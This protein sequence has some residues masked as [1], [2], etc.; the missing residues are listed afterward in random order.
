MDKSSEFEASKVNK[1]TE[2]LQNL[3]VYERLISATEVSVY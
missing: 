2:E 1:I 3:G